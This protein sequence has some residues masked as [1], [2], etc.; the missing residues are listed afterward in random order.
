MKSGI[1]L[2]LQ[3]K[4]Y[5]SNTPEKIHEF[6]S[7]NSYMIISEHAYDDNWCGKGMYFWDNKGNA[8]FWQTHRKDETKIACCFLIIAENEF[9]DL[10]DHDIA[11]GMQKLITK[12]KQKDRNLIDA[13]PGKKIDF[14]ASVLKARVVKVIGSYPHS[15]NSSFFIDSI[16]AHP[17]TSDKIIYC[18]K[19]DSSDIIKHRQLVEEE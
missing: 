8:N 18:V 14:L 1:I 10:S 11:E 7:D 2:K 9:L 5:H 13:K 6:I 17:S 19:P 16:S 4:V 12:M 3:F 15:K